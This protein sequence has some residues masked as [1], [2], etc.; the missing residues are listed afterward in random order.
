MYLYFG[1]RGILTRLE[2]RRRGFRIGTPSS[3]KLGFGALGVWGLMGLC[4][5]IASVLSLSGS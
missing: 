2:M 5:A 4:V 1:V 3:V